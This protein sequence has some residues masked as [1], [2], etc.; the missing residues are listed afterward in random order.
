MKKLAA[1]IALLIVCAGITQAQPMRNKASK[2][3]RGLYV[4]ADQLKEIY[5]YAE[6]K[7]VPTTIHNTL[8][9][10]FHSNT[11]LLVTVTQF[12]PTLA[13]LQSIKSY[14]RDGN[15]VVI[16]CQVMN[17]EARDFFG[18]KDTVEFTGL[19]DS[20]RLMQDGQWVMGNFSSRM[21][22]GVD[23]YFDSL[24]RSTTLAGKDITSLGLNA[25][26]EINFIRIRYGSGAVYI[27]LVPTV[28]TNYFLLEKQNYKYTQAVLS[29]APRN[30]DDIF[31]K[32]PR[33]SRNGSGNQ[34][35]DGSNRSEFSFMSVIWNNPNLRW[36]FLLGLLVLLLLLL[37]GSKRRQRMV[38]VIQP[39]QN[40]TFEFAQTMGDLYFN[41]HNNA[42][43]AAKKI[44]YWQ[45]H[46]RNHYGLAT[47]DM[48]PEFWESLSKKSGQS[49]QLLK[50]IEVYVVRLR[51]RTHLSDRDLVNLS[52]TIDQF[53]KG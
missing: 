52:N 12:L 1:Y 48:G 32:L 13:D 31:W 41:Q 22:D 25:R 37:F 35:Y 33:Y 26:G 36:A 24:P 47:R 9:D 17:T 4:F 18:V 29:Y 19:A 28:L 2:G 21:F 51:N 14:A 46:V 30:V 6:I 10:G 45:E 5:P 44:K 23:C 49:P 42:G 16:F 3:P 7:Q 50:T 27:H 15:S 39:V 34:D 53:Y 20:L 38:P 43:I 11:L 8:S 40:T